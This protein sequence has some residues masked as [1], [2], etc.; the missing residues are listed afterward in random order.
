MKAAQLPPALAARASP[1]VSGDKIIHSNEFQFARLTNTIPIAGDGTRIAKPIVPVDVPSRYVP[2][3]RL[4]ADLVG[5]CSV[6]DP[7]Q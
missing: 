4:Q 3:L 7:V 5:G 6:P 2:K 1:R